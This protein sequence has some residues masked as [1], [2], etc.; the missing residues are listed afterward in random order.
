[1]DKGASSSALNRRRARVCAPSREKEVIGDGFP[2]VLV[3][4]LRPLVSPQS[5]P[6]S[7]PLSL[8]LSL[9]LSVR[10]DMPALRFGGHDKDYRRCLMKGQPLLFTTLFMRPSC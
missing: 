4:E 6:H 9:T 2:F 1:M 7:L 8:S 10:G 3:L 5:S